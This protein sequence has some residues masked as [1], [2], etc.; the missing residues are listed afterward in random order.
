MTEFKPIIHLIT[1]GQ[2][3][4]AHHS[5]M[6]SEKMSQKTDFSIRS[7]SVIWQINHFLIQADHTFY[8]P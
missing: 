7:L 5:E 1:R 6:I 8:I 2:S 3:Y 4:K